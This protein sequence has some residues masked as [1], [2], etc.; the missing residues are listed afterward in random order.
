MNWTGKAIVGIILLF[1]GANLFLQTLG[2]QIGGLIG[3][4]I[5]VL[6]I[7]YGYRK[8]KS[9]HGSNL[10]GM[11]ILIFGLLLAIGHLHIF[12][13]IFI[14]A[15]I[16]YFGYRLVTGEK[17]KRVVDQ[18][19]EVAASTSDASQTSKDAF[20]EEWNKFLEKNHLKS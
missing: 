2:I 15:M 4:A 8:M 3:L 11:A 20:D 9:D 17:T 19:E 18:D 13:G 1:I 12:T 16:I 14:A 6:L 10:L 7:I 5:S